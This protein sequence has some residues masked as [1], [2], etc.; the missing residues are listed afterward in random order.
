MKCKDC[1]V[2]HPDSQKNHGFFESVIDSVIWSDKNSVKYLK[3]ILLSHQLEVVV[4]EQ[5][6]RDLTG[7]VMKL[8]AKYNI[9]Y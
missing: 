5:T 2:P 3:L 9:Q 6:V 8:V 4:L 7:D 1:P